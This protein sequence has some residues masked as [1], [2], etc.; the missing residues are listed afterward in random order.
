M[1]MSLMKMNLMR[2]NPIINL[3]NIVGAKNSHN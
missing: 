1:K 3:K 2:M